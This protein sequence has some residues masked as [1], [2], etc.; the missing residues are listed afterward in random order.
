MNDAKESLE[1]NPIEI[2]TIASEKCPQNKCDGT[3]WIWYKDWSIRNIPRSERVRDEKGNIPDDEWWGKCDC[4]E[5][6]ERQR[7]IDRK[8]DLSNV[9]PIFAGARVSSFKIDKYQKE[10]S[11]E[12]ATLAKKAAGNYVFNFDKMRE[13]GKGLYFHSEIKGSGKTRIAS[14]IANALVREHGVSFAFIKSA[15][16]MEQVKKAM[17][18][19]DSKVTRGDVIKT[20]RDVELLV[21]DDLALKET[22]EFEEGI[23]YDLMDYRLEHKKPTIFT[24][25]VTIAELE[26]IFPGGRVN[27]R[28]N[29]MALEIFMPEES[30]RDQEAEEEDAALE[31][32]LFGKGE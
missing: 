6:M 3:G 16:L 27:K 15:D 31:E 13:S 25:N 12:I 32:I 19:K 4:F 11:R 29:K 14:S 23:L 24:S 5:Q 30:V 2:L 22:T 18:D 1:S 7:E 8:L 9:P 28:I 10:E 20:F 17:F 21:I 26:D